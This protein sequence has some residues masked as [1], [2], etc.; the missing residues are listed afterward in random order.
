M[1]KC[2]MTATCALGLLAA[3]L[4]A[5]ETADAM[6]RYAAEKT[7]EWLQSDAVVSAINSQN[8]RTAGLSAAEIDGLDKNWR[9]QLG[10]VDAPLILS[11]MSH[12][13]SAYL[14]KHVTESGG[15]ITEVFVMDAQGL[16]VASS[17]VT[18][19][20][21]Q[22]DEAKFQQTYGIGPEAM[23][24]GEVELD[25]STQT[26]QAQVSLSLTD[27]A[28]GAVI[29]AVTFGLNAQAFF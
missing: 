13:L 24:V 20:Y 2:L 19:D 5:D 16:N 1:I 4:I 27:P 14:T 29:G 6:S 23:H 7:A 9:A 21:W 18:S 26:Y 3:P 10:Q 8:V 15:R 12:P 11:V 25:E 28:T 22:G 17:T